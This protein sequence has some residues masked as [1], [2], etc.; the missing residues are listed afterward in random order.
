MDIENRMDQDDSTGDKLL[1]F[2]SYFQVEKGSET[3]EEEILQ[4]Q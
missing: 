2:G 4:D 3:N 1:S